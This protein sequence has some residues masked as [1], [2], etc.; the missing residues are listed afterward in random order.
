MTAADELWALLPEIY[1]RLDAE[2]QQNSSPSAPVELVDCQTDGIVEDRQLG[3]LQALIK[4]VGGQADVIAEDLARLY[5]NWFIETCDPWLVP[6]IGE[7]VGARPL[8]PVAGK[9]ALPRGYVANTLAYRRRKGTPAVLEQLARDVTGRPAR[10]VESFQLLETTQYLNHI[11]LA[12]VRTPDLRDAGQLE[13]LGGPFERTAHLL[14]ARHPPTGQYGIKGISLHVW[15][16]LPRHIRRATARAVTNPPDGRYHFDPFGLDTGLFNDPDPEESITSLATERHVPA[17]LGR[18]ELFDR[19][20]G[21]AVR[22][23]ADTGGGLVEVPADQL[24]AADLSDPP[25]RVTTGWRRPPA[26]AL[27]AV[28]PVLGRLAFRAGDVPTAV[29]VQYTTAFP[30]DIGAGPYDRDNDLTEELIQHATFLRVIGRDVPARA[31]ALLSPSIGAALVDWDREA[32]G[33]FGVIAVLDSRSYEETLDITVPAGSS[34]LLAGGTWPEVEEGGSGGH[35]RL[36]DSRP[37]LLGAIGITGSS[38][39][40]GEKPRGRLVLDGLLVEQGLDVHSGDLGELQVLHT[41][42]KPGNTGLRVDLGN[43]DLEIGLDRCVT[44]AMRFAG[45]G[46]SLHVTTSII[47]GDL[48]AHQTEVRLD[49]VTLLGNLDCRTLEASDCLLVGNVT[50][51]RVQQGCV[52]FSYLGSASRTPRRYG[53]QPADPPPQFTSTRF[54]DPGYGQLA[55]RCAEALRKGS[56]QQSDIGAFGELRQPQRDANL[57]AALDEYLRFGLEA[58]I[59]HAT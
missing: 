46:P 29:E 14:D 15:R 20:A 4:L 35:L 7:L 59:F 33:T 40:G 45:E 41:T 21:S 22:V 43:A 30:G 12:N 57:R 25:P 51:E 19:G 24:V 27:A 55:D 58:G 10:V 36:A 11:R 38:G 54:G 5:D 39:G 48:Q 18:R 31:D 53:C 13:R 52:R 16:L 32:A 9:V 3:P 49:A 56:T 17:P 42:V 23:F 28:D 6:Y 2:Y 47:Q 37:H 44:G 1:R 50:V 26:P 8:H 34:L